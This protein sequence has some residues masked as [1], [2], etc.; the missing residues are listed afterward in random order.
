MLEPALRGYFPASEESTISDLQIEGFRPTNPSITDLLVP[1]LIPIVPPEVTSSERQ[2]VLRATM[3]ENVTTSSGSPHTPIKATTAGGILPPLPPSPI[4]TTVV[5]TPST[6][7]SDPIPLSA[8]TTVLF[9]WSVMG[10]PFSYG[11]PDFDT[12]SVITYST[13]HTMG[14]GEGISNAP[15][16]GS[17]VGTIVPFNDIPYGGDHIPP[18][19]PSLV[20]AFQQLIGPNSNYRL[21]GGC[22]SGPSSY[23]TLVG[24]MGFSLFGAFGNNDFSLISFSTG[25]NHDFGQ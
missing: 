4:R 23:T 7:G 1:I 12:K 8:S 24:S 16:Q 2:L 11:M 19:S 6:S 20:G 21:F 9:T 22:S 25:G 10:P 3:E 5:S 13:L 14:L 15:G 18:L 17:I